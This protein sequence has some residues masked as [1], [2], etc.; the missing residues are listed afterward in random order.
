MVDTD[1]WIPPVKQDRAASV[2]LFDEKVRAPTVVSL[3]RDAIPKFCSG[4]GGLASTADDYLKFARL[5]ISGG[6]VDGVRLLKPETVTVM[7]ANRLTTTQLTTLAREEP[8]REGQGF[9]LGVG[10]DIDADKRKWIGPTTN[11]AYGWPGAYSTW[12]RIDPANSMI[13]LY[14]VQCVVPLTPENIP[15]IVTGKGTPLETFQK[16]TYAALAE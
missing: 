9:G 8:H 12:F 11:G 4:G 13:M 2:Y 5:L 7:T 1:F 10:I 14:L 6:E 15:R 16:L 3:P